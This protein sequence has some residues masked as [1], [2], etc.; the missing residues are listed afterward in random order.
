MNLVH[1]LASPFVGG[2]ERQVLGLARAQAARHQTTFLSFAERGLARPFL[3][4]AEREGFAAHELRTNYPRLRAAIA[5]V[6]DWLRQLRA[7]VL[8]TSGYKPDIVGWRAAR[9]AKVPVVGIAHGWTGVTWK[10]RLYE[11]L[12]TLALGFMD[13]VVCVSEATARRARRGGIP[14]RKIRVVRNALDTRPYDFPCPTARANVENLFAPAPRYLVGTVGRLSPEKGMDVFVRSAITL[15]KRRNDVGFVLLGEGP[16]RPALET[17]ISEAGLEGRICL[18]GF[19]RDLPGILP[20]LDVVVSS[21]HTEGLPV[22][23]L[24]AMAAR[25]PV[26][27]T[28]VGGTPEVVCEAQTGYLV[29][30]NQPEALAERLHALLD[31]PQTRQAM[32]QAGR[33]RVCEHFTFTSM[34][35][36]YEQLFSDLP[37]RPVRKEVAHVGC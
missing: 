21:S 22:A 27:A 23:L 16:T 34:A 5:E 17:L 28:A 1:L 11:W 30:P 14:E 7:D 19:C 18:A 3:Q 35:H 24:E 13:R 26:V 37:T 9:Q 31:D 29:P 36:Q 10:V 8:L 6:V 32:G 33:Q 20:G 4:Q 2:P 12:D 15:A 25:L